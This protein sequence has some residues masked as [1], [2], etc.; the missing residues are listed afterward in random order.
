MKRKD[1]LKGSKKPKTTTSIK[2]DKDSYKLLDKLIKKQN[3]QNQW[4]PIG[5]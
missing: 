5:E 4:Y 3:E 2:K 1:W